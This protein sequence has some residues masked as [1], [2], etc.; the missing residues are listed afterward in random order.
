MGLQLAQ[1]IVFRGEGD[2]LGPSQYGNE[3][4]QL[5]EFRPCQSGE[6]GVTERR[7][8]GVTVDIIREGQFF[9]QAA[10]TTSQL[11]INPERY[12]AAPGLRSSGEKFSNRTG[13]RSCS[14]NSR[15]MEHLAI[16]KSSVFASSGRGMFQQTPER[17]VCFIGVRH[18]RQ[19]ESDCE[20]YRCEF[21]G[22]QLP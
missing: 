10:N 5:F 17:C 19:F 7:P 13:N 16:C 3:D 22:L 12:K 6:A 9:L 4:F 2:R 15:S 20:V 8:V 14:R 1:Q 21:P 11:T 18:N